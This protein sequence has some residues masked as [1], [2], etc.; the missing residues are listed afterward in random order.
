V[1]PGF[2]TQLDGVATTLRD[3]VNNVVSPMA[4]NIAAASRNQTAAGALQFGIA[5]DGGAVSTVS[6][7]GADWSGAGG[8]AA[9]Q[10]AL[11]TAL[12]TS[13][14]V[15]NATATVTTNTDGSLA[16][17]I[18]PTAT[19]ALQV[20]ASGANVGFSTLLG[21]TPVGS[22]GIGGRAFFAGTD[23]STLALSADVAGNPAAVTAG[24]AGR[25]PLDASIALRL[26]DMSTSSTGAD[27]AY[28]ALIVGLGIAAKDVQTRNTIQQQSV[29]SLDS[30]RISQAGVNT[31]EEMTNMVEFQKAYEASAKFISSID[32]MLSTLINMVGR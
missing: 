26:G 27:A 9:L 13:I 12:N 16:V 10:T 6:V 21:T 19:H 14:G 3:Q 30:A 31:D 15:G 5:L 25:G 7:T 32:S 22:D 4:G 17:A 28:N 23:A 24:V 1:L 18:A 11:Q 29:Q 8:A 2:L 20:Q